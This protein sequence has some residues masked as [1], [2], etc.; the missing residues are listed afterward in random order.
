MDRLL[1]W[2]GGVIQQS[3]GG[4]RD[5]SVAAAGEFQALVSSP[6]AAVGDHVISSTTWMVSRYVDARGR[7][8][9][10]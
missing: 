2:T 6:M 4:G 7:H 5:G 9:G 1:P 8:L 3:M 10:C